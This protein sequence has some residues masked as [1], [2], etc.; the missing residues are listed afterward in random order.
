MQEVL[1]AFM[2]F[3][4]LNTF[5]DY[6]LLLDAAKRNWNSLR[7]SE[8]PEISGKSRKKNYRMHN[9]PS[10]L[11]FL[12]PKTSFPILQTFLLQYQGKEPSHVKGEFY[13]PQAEETT[14]EESAVPQQQVNKK[15]Q[16]N[17]WG[18][19]NRS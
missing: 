6:T 10:V 5:I 12:W 8:S 11:I 7:K 19:V 4:A 15:S 9:V 1:K 16:S 17:L 18:S 2:I 14:R 3:W 13:L